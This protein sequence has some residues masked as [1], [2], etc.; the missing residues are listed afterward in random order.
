MADTLSSVKP[1][2]WICWRAVISST[3]LP[4]RGERF[5]AAFDQGG[6]IFANSQPF[7][8]DACLAGFDCVASR[9]H[10]FTSD[11][12]PDPKQIPPGQSARLRPDRREQIGITDSEGRDGKEIET[13]DGFDQSQ[14]G[15]AK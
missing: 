12:F 2:S 5:V 13:T 9:T 10:P 15:I 11:V 3:Q 14:R 6:Q 1:R 4:R 8:A 7:A